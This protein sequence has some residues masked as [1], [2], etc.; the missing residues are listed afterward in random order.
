MTQVT[1]PF[2]IFY[3]D[4]GTPL[5]SGMI[6]IGQANQDPRTNP[7]TVYRDEART[8]PIAQPII[9]LDGRPA[10]QGAPVNLYVNEPSYS[11]S[12]QNR[13]GSPVTSATD[14]GLSA[15]DV[16]FLP[17]G[18]GAALRTVEAKLRESVSVKDFGAVGDGVANDAPAFSLAAAAASTVRV[19]AGTYLL[20]TSPTAA[21]WIVDEGATFT[22]AGRL[23]TLTG[24]VVSNVGA[25]RSLESESSFYSGVFGY[26]EQNAALSGYGTI[27]LHGFA[28]SAGGTGLL[29]EADIGVAGVAVHDLAASNGGVWALYGTAVRQAG[30]GGATHALELDVAN[31]G[32]EV[33]LFPH[34]MFSSGATP[35]AWICSGGEVTSVGGAAGV[36]SCA[37]G[38]VQNDSQSV[39]TASFEKGIIFHNTSIKGADG[40]GTIG[41]AIAF[42]S[43]HAMQWFNN[44]G[45]IVAEIVGTAVT[46]SANNYRL[47]FSNFGLIV[48]DRA[49]GVVLFQIE[50]TASGVNG[51]GIRPGATGVAGELIALG[52]DTDIDLQLRAK[53]SGRIKYGTFASNA[54]APV[55]GYVEIKTDDGTIRKLA[56]IA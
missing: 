26:L 48:Q 35:C 22:G 25:F 38:I 7:V 13:F 49:S 10:F 23:N 17:A 18:T 50:K 15:Q 2:P 11:I 33:P 27:G 29:A 28:R 8:V 21:T 20:N 36:A 41:S 12:V 44:S 32:T 53:G 6:Y 14:I 51:I 54:D 40:T 42:A 4:D 30:V 39:K 46:S 1:E 3:D 56:V 34:Q 55:T 19:P 5:E 47:D 9:T 16:S 37:I 45:T 31:M 52:N 24:H 43:G